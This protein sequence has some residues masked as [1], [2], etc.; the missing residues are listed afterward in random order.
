MD[1]Y[2]IGDRPVV[3]ATFAD[4]NGS[5]GVSTAVTFTVRTPAGIETAYTNTNP[6]VAATGSNVW[7]LTLPR[8]DTAGRWVVRAEST[9]GL[10]AAVE[11]SF[12]VRNSAIVP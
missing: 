12:N 1:T 9:A 10:Q 11:Q 4:I 2:D 5:T 3:T 8:L 7:T 6:A